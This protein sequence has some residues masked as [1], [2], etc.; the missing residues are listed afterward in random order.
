MVMDSNVRSSWWLLR[1]V[2]GVVPI[3]AGLDKFLGLLADWEAYLSPLARSLLPVS[4]HTFMLVVGVVEIAAGAL[5]LA[6]PRIGAWVV[7]AWL[8][9]IALQLLTTGKYFDVAVRDLVMASGAYVLGRLSAAQERSPRRAAQRVSSG[10]G[11]PAP[12]AA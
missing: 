11:A 4:A 12:E 7:S 5:T 9:A 3:V 10:L 1:V 2:F 8:V 6:R